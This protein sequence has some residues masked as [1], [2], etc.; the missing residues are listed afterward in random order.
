MKIDSFAC[1]VCGKQKKEANH[2]F[3]GRE[4]PSSAGVVIVQ[5]DVERAVI[6]GDSLVL[7]LN[8]DAHLCGAECATQWLSK[9]LLTQ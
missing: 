5:W 8:K 3:R 7:D 1:D 4:L 9:N 2:W 6:D